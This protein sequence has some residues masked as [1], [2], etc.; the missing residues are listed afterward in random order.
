MTIKNPGMAKKYETT[1]NLKNAQDFI[2][3]SENDLDSK[4]E[5]FTYERNDL[6]DVG[7]T[8]EKI[9]TKC[10]LN[11]LDIPIEYRED[12]RMNKIIECGKNY[13]EKNNYYRMLNGEPN[14]E[15]DTSDYIMTSIGKY[16]H[17]LTDKEF[18]ALNKEGEIAKIQKE[19]P[20]K[21][22]LRYLDPN[23]KIDYYI[24]RKTKDFYI[25][26]YPEYILDE[27]YVKQ[28][29]DFYYQILVYTINVIYSRAFINQEYYDSYIIIYML[30]AT[31]QKFF[32]NHVTNLMRRDLYDIESI[33]NMFL[34]YGLP[35]FED[36]PLKYQRKILK[37]MN[38]LLSYKGTDKVLVDL[39]HIFGFTDTELYRYYLVKDYIRNGD[40]N[41]VI[42]EGDNFTLKFAQV[43]LEDKDISSYLNTNFLYQTYDE[44]VHDDPYWGLND[45]GEIDYDLIKEIKQNDFNYI[46]TKYL[47]VGSIFNMSKTVFETSYF[48]NLI[49][50]LQERNEIENLYLFDSIIKPDGSALSLFNAVAGL[51][52][53]LFRRFGY[54]DNILCEPTA[55]ATVYGFNF[56]SDL[57]E[58]KRYAKERATIDIDGVKT[59]HFNSKMIDEVLK[60]L[61]LPNNPRKGELINKYFK[62]K[63]FNDQIQELMNETDNLSLYRELDAI[64]TYNMYCQNIND[65]YDGG[66]SQEFS[67]YTEYLKKNDPMFFDWIQYNTLDKKGNIDKEKT[68]KALTIVLEALELYFN[69]DQFYSLFMH[70]NV[71]LDLVRKYLMETIS[72]F[73]AYTVEIKKIN[74]YYMFDDHYINTIRLFTYMSRKSTISGIDSIS[75]NFADEICRTVN[76]YFDNNDLLG[77]QEY[78]ETYIH[79]FKEDRFDLSET[80]M[81]KVLKQLA[82]KN[83]INEDIYASFLIKAKELGLENLKDLANLIKIIKGEEELVLRENF[84]KTNTDMIKAEKSNLIDLHYLIKLLKVKDKVM[85]YDDYEVVIQRILNKKEIINFTE[86]KDDM[87]R[88]FKYADINEISD[89]SY[90]S[91]NLYLNDSNRLLEGN[92]EELIFY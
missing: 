61:E 11:K 45:N 48:F 64:H 63:E 4:F 36:I 44:V 50:K 67:T 32:T 24:A 27:L 85:D 35:F 54:S 34:S 22:Y 28:I 46:S 56:D 20:Y 86:V 92:R 90:R 26:K 70:T 6:I 91:N 76:M 7:I 58:L 59:H 83:E 66:D 80:Y 33:R 18:Y 40:T 43:A 60:I 10:L 19:N 39:T 30:T 52:L 69:E 13:V 38:K 87:N 5:Y 72:I 1:E 82:E 53:L 84:T 77:L 55:I 41:D 68:M 65:L 31:L 2:Y 15:E 8:D 51:Y 57:D 49:K 25:M 74:I 3:V 78:I 62:S 75:K 37:N 16:V 17:E 14:I 23:N 88:K 9:I 81:V 73:K 12:L 89:S 47:S 29:I 21:Y 79:I 42:M 71:T